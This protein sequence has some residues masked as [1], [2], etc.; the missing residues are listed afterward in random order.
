MG[1][2]ENVLA[3]G[4][5]VERDLHP[6]WLTVL[7]PGALGVVLV[8]AGWLTVWAT[9]DDGAGNRI[10]WIVIGLLVLAA[11]PA[12]LVPFLR[13]RTTRYVITTHRVMVRRGILAKAGKDITLSKI[14]DVSF[15]QTL[16]DRIIRAGTLDIESAGDSADESLRYIPRS[17]AVQQLI[18]R[19]VDEDA[20][21]RAG[22]M[23]ERAEQ[24]PARPALAEEKTSA[25]GPDSGSPSP[26]PPG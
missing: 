9:P 1:F 21:R 8:A 14:T 4:E 13:W 23:V 25:A 17:D 6:H 22:L 18:N 24:P 2:P 26:T 7:G 3:S 19:L 15:R 5:R 16:L 10:Q 12:V 11:V 20:N